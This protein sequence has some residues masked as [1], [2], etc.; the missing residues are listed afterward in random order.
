MGSLLRLWSDTALGL[1]CFEGFTG[2]RGSISKDLLYVAQAPG[3]KLSWLLTRGL[4]PSQRPLHRAPHS[5]LKGVSI[6]REQSR[7]STAF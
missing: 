6:P 4:G 7:G 1:Q 3:C 5:I 2:A